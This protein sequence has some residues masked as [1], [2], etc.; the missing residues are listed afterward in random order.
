[1]FFYTGGNVLCLDLWGRQGGASLQSLHFSFAVGAFIA[2]V[3][4]HPFFTGPYPAELSPLINNS[5]KID[6]NLGVTPPVSSTFRRVPRFI[7]EDVGNSS[8]V[9]D[10]LVSN[11]FE[12]TTVILPILNDSQLDPLHTNNDKTN[13][14]DVEA[15]N[16]STEVDTNNEKKVDD[17]SYLISNLTNSNTSSINPLIKNE[18]DFK[19]SIDNLN[20]SSIDLMTDK[21][22]SSNLTSP[23][24]KI[25]KPKPSFVDAN[26][27]PEEDQSQWKRKPPSVSIKSE[28]NKNSTSSQILNISSNNLSKSNKTNITQQ[29][30]Q[31]DN[32]S[33][34]IVS[35]TNGIITTTAAQTTKVTEANS[36]ILSTTSSYVDF[37]NDSTI[38]DKNTP[39][40]FYIETNKYLIKTD[41]ASITTTP[42]PFQAQETNGFVSDVVPI[43]TT[44]RRKDFIH[45][46]TFPIV[47]IET[48][49]KTTEKSFTLA[50]VAEPELLDLKENTDDSDIQK[51]SEISSHDSNIGRSTPG[52]GVH[53]SKPGTYMNESEE[54][55]FFLESMAEKFKNYGVTKIHLAYITVGIFVL[56]NSL[57]SVVI[58]CHNPREPRS[59]QDGGSFSDVR[60]GRAVLFTLVFSIFMFTAEAL[61][62][63]VHHLLASSNSQKDGFSITDKD[64]DGV[65]LFWGIMCI[66]RFLCILISGCVKLKPGKLL[67]VSTFLTVVGTSLLC[68]GTFG[69]S[70]F[71]WGGIVVLALGLAPIL[72]TSFLWMSQYMRVTHRMCALMIILSSFGNSLTHSALTHVVGGSHI[73]SYILV[74]ISFVSLV[75]L[76]TSMIILYATDTSKTVGVPV[77]YQLAN[78][79]EEED[80]IELTPS[81]SSMFSHPN[82]RLL[83][84]GEAG[85]ALLID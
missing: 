4:I 76:V 44:A 13:N 8:N 83:E 80:N 82:H 25:P 61:Q 2:P 51:D 66:A 29:P 5:S 64:V 81:A 68:V 56:L 42:S 34:P 27:L 79:Q 63:A 12:V 59:K 22:V 55:A 45:D 75:F 26:R 48:T 31:S 36:E 6:P 49:L 72:P 69:R 41:S 20:K 65:A 40:K 70:D 17:D 67:V 9:S 46:Q 84:N 15:S 77:G 73:Y 33:I 78:Q 52:S 1:M 3:V 58:L 32:S 60:K 24:T 54:T 37:E 85:Q 74:V 28:N 23:M 43:E 53:L 14:F 62:G 18:T 35:T 38:Q 10:V 39:E 71:L 50:T 16:L 7:S 21:T 47:D 11:T 19:I 30:I 57:I